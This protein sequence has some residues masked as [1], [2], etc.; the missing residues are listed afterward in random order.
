VKRFYSAVTVSDGAIL[1]DGRPVK[2]PARNALRL[3][4]DR[5]AE[6]VAQEWTA[7][8]DTIDP[9]AMPMTGL[10]N[11][12]IDRVSPDPAAFATPLAAYAET[13]LLCYR[14]DSPADLVARQT[15]TWDRLLGWA[16][17]RY[18]V[19]FTVTSGIVHAAQP[20][21]TVRRLGEALAARDP[22]AL[23]AMSPLVT[24]GGSL[25][26]ALALAEGAVAAEAAFDL[27]HLDELW[28]AEQWGE[29]MLATQAREARRRDFLAAARFLTLL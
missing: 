9:R 23:A 21:A 7:Q 10:S 2:T 13:D 19:R 3:R 17:A 1:L 25:A 29:D 27:T 28:Q 18:D 26:T 8:G 16:Q 12:A 15:E 11:A 20:A 22:F 6:A 14:A 5:L 4:T 24:I